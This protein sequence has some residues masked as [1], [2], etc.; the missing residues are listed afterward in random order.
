M[1]GSAGSSWLIRKLLAAVLVLVV[2][3]AG[4]QLAGWLLEQ[5]VPTLLVLAGLL[6]LL[7][8]LFRG[9]RQ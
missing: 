8:R 2:V 3:A 6:W 5:L 9:P 7:G 1:N 4:T